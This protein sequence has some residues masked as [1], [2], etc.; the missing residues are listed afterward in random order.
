MKRETDKFIII[1]RSIKLLLQQ[2]IEQ[3]IANQQMYKDQP[4]STINQDLINIQNTA[5]QQNTHSP[6]VPTEHLPRQTN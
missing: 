6:P 3:E 2:L 5:Q 4:N 1:A